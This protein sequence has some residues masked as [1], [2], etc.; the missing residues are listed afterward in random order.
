MH[1]EQAVTM[2][3][4]AFHSPLNLRLDDECSMP[5]LSEAVVRQRLRPDLKRWDRKIPTALSLYLQRVPPDSSAK[6]GRSALKLYGFHI[7]TSARATICANTIAMHKYLADSVCQT[8]LL[9]FVYR[10]HKSKCTQL[11]FKL[12]AAASILFQ[13]LTAGHCDASAHVLAWIPQSAGPRRWMQAMIRPT[14]SIFRSALP[15]NANNQPTLWPRDLQL[16][17]R[18]PPK[19]LLPDGCVPARPTRQD[20]PWVLR[21]DCVSPRLIHHR[22]AHGHGIVAAPYKTPRAHRNTRDMSMDCHRLWRQRRESALRKIGKYG[23]E[24]KG[25]YTTPLASAGEQAC[26]SELRFFLVLRKIS[27]S[28]ASAGGSGDQAWLLDVNRAP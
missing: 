1:V 22:H 15:A 19:S 3:S 28:S 2:R 10:T 21:E 5:C 18:R 23:S 14:C 11:P 12:S 13:P 17:R 16:L 27:V 25:R 6:I 20:P 24:E 8:R 7:C 9:S 26:W 4:V